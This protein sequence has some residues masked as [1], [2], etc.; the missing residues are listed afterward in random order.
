MKES[1]NFVLQDTPVD[2]ERISWVNSESFIDFILKRRMNVWVLV[3]RSDLGPCISRYTG[4]ETKHL[5]LSLRL[6]PYK[7]IIH[8]EAKR[9][10]TN[11]PHRAP[12]YEP[13]A[14]HASDEKFDFIFFVERLENI[15]K[16]HKCRII[17]IHS[18]KESKIKWADDECWKQSDIK[19]TW[20]IWLNYS[21][22]SRFRRTSI[23]NFSKNR[24]YTAHRLRIE[25]SRGR[26]IERKRIEWLCCVRNNNNNEHIYRTLRSEL[27]KNFLRSIYF[28]LRG[29]SRMYHLLVEKYQW[30]NGIFNDWNEWIVNRIDHIADT[31]A[32]GVLILRTMAQEQKKNLMYFDRLTDNVNIFLGS[33]NSNPFVCW[34][35]SDWL[36][37]FISIYF[38][39]RKLSDDK[40]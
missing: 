29:E 12:C 22:I 11:D 1:L 39:W 26:K 30:K 18:L 4:W 2:S 7:L 34:T 21:L 15:L 40:K 32:V 13:A 5:R 14:Y 23:W 6:L 25:K 38:L 27:L 3:R 35:P 33:V 36:L 16:E 9:H 20:Q 37:Y 10:T 24:Q 19:V 31:V 28:L 17:S 8:N